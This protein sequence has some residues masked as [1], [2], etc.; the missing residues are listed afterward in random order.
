MTS[1]EEFEEEIGREVG[2]MGQ[3]LHLSARARLDGACGFRFRA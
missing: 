1:R 3:L 2:L